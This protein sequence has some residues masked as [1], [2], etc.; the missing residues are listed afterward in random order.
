MLR[1]SCFE[2]PASSFLLPAEKKHFTK[3]KLYNKN[4][5]FN[6]MKSISISLFL[7]CFYLLSYSQNPNPVVLVSGKVLNERNMK[8][9]EGKV[10]YEYLP[11]G[12]EAGLA[13]TNP[14]DGTYKII[15]PFGKNYGYYAL[16]EGYYSVT[17]NL[18]VTSLNKYAE[19]DEQ[20]LYLAPVEIDQ[21]VRINNI[22]FEGNTASLKS[23][24]YPELNRLAEFFKLN[25]KIEIEVSGHTDNSGK[26]EELKKL[27][28]DRAQ[29]VADYLISKKMDSKRITVIGFGDTQPIG[30]NNSDEGK[31]M[32]KRVEF[33]ITS[34]TKT[35]KK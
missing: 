23:E 24:S 10:L 5:E 3:H 8:P 2:L 19:I 13:R 18:D 29:A 17:K 1:A 28:Q 33:K 7:A 26:P 14:T 30:F 6:K 4:N 27:S 20:N 16:A 35:K 31:E 12:E 32:N 9:V 25:K 11:G 34:L 22:F 21:V 15:L